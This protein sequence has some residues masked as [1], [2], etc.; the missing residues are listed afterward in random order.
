MRA[1]SAHLVS[2]DRQLRRL[3]KSIL[4]ALDIIARRVAGVSTW[5][6]AF[7]DEGELLTEWSA[8]GE[9]EAEALRAELEHDRERLALGE[10]MLTAKFPRY[11]VYRD[12]VRDTIRALDNQ[13]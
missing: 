7:R 6:D 13:L 4:S 12:E 8:A 9:V 5:R 3:F 11:P 10:R 2:V 1:M